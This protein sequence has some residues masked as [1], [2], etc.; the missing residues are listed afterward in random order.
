MR[1][2]E[3]VM[4]KLSNALTL[5]IMYKGKIIRSTWQESK[6]KREEHKPD[7]RRISHASHGSG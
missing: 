4:K 3:K 7:I 5:H 6:L 1:R 2:H